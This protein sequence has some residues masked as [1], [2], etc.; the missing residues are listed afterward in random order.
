MKLA[1]CFES[2]DSSRDIQIK[3]LTRRATIETD[4]CE[5]PLE[6]W[7]EHHQI[8][9]NVAYA[10]R[11]ARFLTPYRWKNHK[12]SAYVDSDVYFHRDPRFVMDRADK[13]KAVTVLTEGQ[14]LAF[15]FFNNELCEAITP[16][17]VSQVYTE[18]GYV[19]LA[20]LVPRDQI[21]VYPANF[22]N[23]TTH[24]IGACLFHSSKVEQL[25]GT[26]MNRVFGNPTRSSGSSFAD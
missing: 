6:L 11:C 25:D 4:Y 24:H 1:V 16:Y 3:S 19:T 9:R 17:S 22:Y 7:Q 2:R 5:V 23:K 26:E 14:G 18:K 10:E 21:A 12:F 8:T 13:T 20:D 15:I